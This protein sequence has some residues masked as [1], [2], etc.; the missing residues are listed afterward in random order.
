VIRAIV[1]A[2]SDIGKLHQLWYTGPQRVQ[3]AASDAA[4]GPPADP[5]G[6]LFRQVT[7]LPA[8]L[9][10]A[11]LLAGLPLLLLGHFSGF[12][13]RRSGSPAA[14]LVLLAW[15]SMPLQAGTAALRDSASPTRTPW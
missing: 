13:C 2:G 14:V 12:R 7:V 3:P 6:R 5:A 1:A 4:A 10:A 11:W 8:L 9:A 15:R